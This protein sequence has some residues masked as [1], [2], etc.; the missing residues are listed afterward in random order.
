MFPCFSDTELCARSLT[1]Y[2]MVLY[3]DEIL[4]VFHS[5]QIDLK[6]HCYLSIHCNIN[7]NVALSLPSPH[8]PTKMKRKPMK[9]HVPQWGSVITWQKSYIIDSLFT[10]SWYH[11]IILIC[12][13]VCPSVCPFRIYSVVYERTST[14]LSHILTD[15]AVLKGKIVSKYASGSGWAP[16]WQ[17]A[18]YN[19]TIIGVCWG[20]RQAVSDVFSI[21]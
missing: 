8:L 16:H 20:H 10:V 14:K 13:S 2:I 5:V 12:P 3:C 7:E 21:F 6:W 4:N 19:H 18:S 15:R 9:R 1:C 11:T 17:G